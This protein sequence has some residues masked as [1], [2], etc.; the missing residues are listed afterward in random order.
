M[1]DAAATT[2]APPRRVSP[3]SSVPTTLA[4]RRVACPRLTPPRR[5][6]NHHTAR[7][8]TRRTRT[9]PHAA[10]AAAAASRS[11]A[12]G[13]NDGAGTDH[14][15]N[16]RGHPGGGAVDT[17][18]GGGLRG[19][20][21][22]HTTTTNTSWSLDV[23]SLARMPRH[24]IIPRTCHSS[25][26]H[27]NRHAHWIA[28]I[29]LP[30][31]D[32]PIAV[33]TTATTTT[34]AN[35]TL[36]NTT[37]TTPAVKV[38]YVQYEFATEKEARKFC[39]AYAPPKLHSNPYCE[40]CVAATS[41]TRTTSSTA[42][43][44]FNN[45][46][47]R[48]VRR[49]ATPGLFRRCRNCGVNCCDA[50]ATKWGVRMVPKTY[51]ASM[52]SSSSSSSSSSLASYS[53]HSSTSLDNHTTSNH[54]PTGQGGST[55]GASLPEAASATPFSS[56]SSSHGGGGNSSNAN[57]SKV[58]RVCKAC[59][60]L[61]NAFCMS[62]LQ[63]RYQDALQLYNTGNV[64]LRTCFADIH[65]EAM[66]P[67]H[68]AVLGGSL[69][70]VTWLVEKECCPIVATSSSGGGGGVPRSVQ[71]S[72]SRTLLD[73]AMTGRPKLDILS[74]FIANK[75]LSLTSDVKDPSLAS[76]TLELIF[77]SQASSS[78]LLVSTSLLPVS[79]NRSS[80]SSSSSSPNP[81]TGMTN[82]VVGGAAVVVEDVPSVDGPDGEED[83]EAAA[84]DEDYDD[85]DDS[86]NDEDEPDPNACHIC[87]EQPMDCVLT[88]CGHQVCCTNCG[89]RLPHCPVC[90]SPCSYLRIYR[91]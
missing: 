40:L 6:Q 78:A 16:R 2:T 32:S 1:T 70:C 42:L 72:A 61:S 17:L 36:T 76:K 62:L 55:T 13:S 35:S 88:P 48:T 34:T 56:S 63:G 8:R 65:R 19:S 58:V 38:R 66:F 75:G 44:R 26:V 47:A 73:L 14:D 89:T 31:T 52:S 81:S 5:F 64:N 43:D 87:F 9:P 60:W 77:K 27:S 50:H 39:K 83:D 91:S 86:Q 15:K 3:T 18:C 71:T 68:C 24:Q 7:T 90:K 4:S 25:S 45:H 23:S 20:N 46:N 33:T 79:A 80:A 74:Y 49:F 29:A 10:A 84:M 51:L 53:S 69:E 30:E 57:T 11:S 37:N 12:R 82:D 67:I 28:T 85:D 41:S 59:D 22:N 54:Q 21:S